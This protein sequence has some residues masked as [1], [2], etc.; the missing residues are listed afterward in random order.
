MNVKKP[1]KRKSAN[2]DCQDGI[3]LIHIRD[4][5]D[6]NTDDSESAIKVSLFL[7]IYKIIK[8]IFNLNFVPKKKFNSYEIIRS[9]TAPIVLYRVIF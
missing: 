3:E 8:K 4:S 5:S 7:N 9:H 6:H 2:R 1:T